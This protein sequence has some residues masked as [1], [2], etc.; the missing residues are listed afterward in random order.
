MHIVFMCVKYIDNILTFGSLQFQQRS[1]ILANSQSGK[2][3]TTL[4]SK[5]LQFQCNNKD[6]DNKNK[7]NDK[8]GKKNNIEDKKGNDKENNYKEDND[9]NNKD[10]DNE[11]NDNKDNNNP[12][13]KNEEIFSKG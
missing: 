11:D 1:G 13:N 5:N 4:N 2:V 10:N 9:N 3:K 6:V 12:D 8:K 7:D